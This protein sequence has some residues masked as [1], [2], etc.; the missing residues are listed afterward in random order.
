MK[1]STINYCYYQNGIAKN[2][3]HKGINIHGKTNLQ[4]RTSFKGVKMV[5]TDIDGTILIP[6]RASFTDRVKTCI[7][8][9]CKKN[10]KVVLV[11]GRMNAVMQRFN[12]ELHLDTP[13][14]SYQGGLVTQ[15]NNIL[16]EKYLTSKQTEDILS[17]AKQENIHINL[18]NND[19]LYAQEENPTIQKYYDKFH[20]KY[21][22]KDFGGIKKNKV[23]KLLAIDY[24][25][26]SRIDRYES[27]LSK[28][29]PDIN[30]VKSNP[31]HLEFSSKEASK[32]CAVKFLQKYWGLKTDEILTIGDQNNDIALLEAGG[33]KVA[34]GNATDK[35]KKCADY[36]TK[37]VDNDGFS[38]AMEKYCNL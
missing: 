8:N 7:D 2:N 34:M 30:I 16:Y 11:S 21:Q 3:S 26:P 29:F 33:I 4:G 38:F 36:V 13:I 12:K 20:T 27:E 32:Y 5:A 23:N 25:N 22:I 35:L 10:I 19:I 37:S 31:Y 18:Y 6:G 14:C 15:G 17:W 28:A 9:L 24:D 1:V